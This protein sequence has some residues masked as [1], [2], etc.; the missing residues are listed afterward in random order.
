[1]CLLLALLPLFSQAQERHI[2][3]VIIDGE[4]SE[5]MVQTAVQLLATDSTFVAGGVSD[6]RGHFTLTAP[7][8]GDYLLKI[9]SIGYVA[10]T[11]KI[12]IDNDGNLDLGRIKMKADATWLKEIT[13]TAQALKVVVVEDTFIY[14]SSAYRT[15]EGSVVEELVK[16]LPGAT[17]D[18][19]G[20][21][22][23]NGKAVE[24]VKVDGRE[25]MTGDTKTAIKNLPTSIIDKVK[26]YSDKSDNT[27][28]TGIDDGEEIMTL[29][30]D[31]KPGMNKGLLG[32][33]DLAYGT[34]ERY[35]ERGMAAW[36]KDKLRV[37]A[38]G[39]FNNTN[40]M[41]FGGRGGGFSRGR[42]GLNTSNMAGVNVNYEETDKLK[43][44]GSIR[45]N[46][47][48]NDASTRS[49][50]EQFV[51][52]ETAVQSFA[53]NLS[54]AYSKNKSFSAQARIEWKPDT[55][56]TVMFRPSWSWSDN[57]GRSGQSAA[58]FSADPYTF[59]SD[60]LANLELLEG[61]DII[62]NSSSGSSLTYGTT[63]RIGGQMQATRRFGSK[64]RNVSLRLEGNYSSSGDKNF[65]TD[66]V[67]L[68]GSDDDYSINRYS[69]TPSKSW[70]Y[71]V[72]T[73]YSEPVAKKTY[74]QLSYR[75]Q[76]TY[77]KSAR[78]TYDFSDISLLPADY[79]NLLAS[80]GLSA[81]PAYRDW[82]TYLPD[83]Y[84]DYLDSDLSRFSEYR[85]YTHTIELQ[86]RRIRDNYNFNIGVQVQPQHTTFRQ[87]YLAVK[88]DTTR[89]VL[90]V[91]PTINFRYYFSR[92][93]Q[94]RL[95]YRG[96]TSQP[97]MADLVSIT[98]NSDPLNITLGNP[99]LK[100]SFK[101]NLYFNYNNY[102]AKHNQV[103]ELH[104]QITATRNAT[105]QRV[106]YDTT[107]GG[108]TTRPENING[109]WDMTVGGMYNIA[110]DSL[111]RW[112]INSST[113]YSFNNYVG[114]VSVSESAGSQ[115]NITKSHSVN[116]RLAG[117]YRNDWLEIE[118][119]GTL[120]YTGSVNRLQP[121][122]D[123][124]T[125]GISY[126]AS[127]TITCPWG[128]S[129]SSDIHMKSRRGYNDTSLNTNEPVWNAQISQSLLKGK[130][131]TVT[132]Q[133]YDILHRQ[134]NLSR[135][136]SA[137]ERQ[138]TEYNAINAY[139]MLHVVYRFNLFGTNNMPDRHPPHEQ[140]RRPDFHRDEFRPPHGEG[141]PPPGGGMPPGGMM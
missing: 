62:K 63:K 4:T 37:M 106:T 74:I 38:M 128:T 129:L 130:R 71:T 51:T 139:G 120:N 92:Q 138:D 98:D 34:K 30:F 125:W 105:T 86:L 110:L 82:R 96:I 85:T 90:N 136:I 41:G 65:S 134:S 40:D 57:D 108:R 123:L 83:D 44:D 54:Q 122:A 109:N 67:R 131:L 26:A 70:D 27:K 100:P 78:T 77:S 93:H 60:P 95:Q 99:G 5:A 25:F 21:V 19:D 137:M 135:T 58:T 76:N 52:S 53:N 6:E 2:T 22:T 16:R 64:G 133:W 28:M 88:T 87:N 42:N 89:N 113:D 46:H 47:N 29:D 11:R 80:L 31:I 127:T 84:E 103:V 126:G 12:V 124:D 111:G 69:L 48:T 45:W 20:N 140:G 91:S 141:G 18:D 75:F 132:L 33:I 118:L 10:Q 119:D 116:E 3:G 55:M 24:R 81:V 7:V 59:T 107:T 49:S 32:N 104:G 8:G 101:H 112:N 50:S 43:A 94:L 68:Y 102:I 79:V 73:S 23:I 39:N 56:T 97:A 66:N 117:S 121:S 15:P 9:S 14:N 72:Q 115:R 36:M 61:L 35:A 13:K 17:V 1:M 114:L